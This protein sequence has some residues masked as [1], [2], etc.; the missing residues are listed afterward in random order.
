MQAALVLQCSLPS[1]SHGLIS[2]AQALSSCSCRKAVFQLAAAAFL[3]I[4]S[5]LAPLL[6]LVVL[7]PICGN[8]CMKERLSP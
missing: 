4:N 7:S 2:F 8:S 5:Q 1:K 6:I 3:S